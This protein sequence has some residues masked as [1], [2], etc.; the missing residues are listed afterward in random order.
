MTIKITPA[1]MIGLALIAIAP[2]ARAE[3]ASKAYVDEKENVLLYN[4]AN[5][6]STTVESFNDRVS[7]YGSLAGMLETMSQYADDGF[8]DELQNRAYSG[9]NTYQEDSNAIIVTN[10]DGRVAKATGGYI[11]NDKIS[12]SAAI[13]MGKIAFPTPPASCSTKGCMLMF[14]NNQYVWE[15]VTRDTDESIATTGAVNA[16]ATTTTVTINEAA[17]TYRGYGSDGSYDYDEQ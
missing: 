10:S 1:I 14:Y 17:S 5:P 13:E 11:T 15:P 16:T 9:V 4:T 7:D 6:S 8:M 2:N 3:I 12:S